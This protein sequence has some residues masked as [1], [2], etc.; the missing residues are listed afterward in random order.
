MT[1]TTNATRRVAAPPATRARDFNGSAVRLVKLLAPQRRTA[2][3]V[4]A[5][6]VAGTAIGVVVPRILGHATDLLFNGVIGRRLPAG[7]TKDQAVA[8]AR[9]H[10]DNAFADLLSGMHVIPGHGVDFGAVARTLALAL[11]MYLVAAAD[12]L[13][14]GPA[15]QRDSATDSAGAARASRR[16]TAPAAVGLLRHPAT[17]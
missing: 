13:R 16:Q 1:A 10:G 17:R 4:V 15:A 9:A 8:A 5:L 6:S 2:V 14:A 12:D 11:G 7:I 3:A